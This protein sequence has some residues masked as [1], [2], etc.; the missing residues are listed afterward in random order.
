MGQHFL[1]PEQ[2]EAEVGVKV[3]LLKAWMPE[4]AQE[5]RATAAAHPRLHDVEMQESAGLCSA[6]ARHIFA[7]CCSSDVAACAY[8]G[9]CK[10]STTVIV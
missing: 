10:A 5:G 6:R 7:E 8:I 4:V 1:Q 2:F 3:E 9:N